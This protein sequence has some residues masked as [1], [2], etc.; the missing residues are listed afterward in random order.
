MA[1]KKWLLMY[2]GQ[3]ALKEHTYQE[4]FPIVIW[5]DDCGSITEPI[6]VVDDFHGK[7]AKM[8]HNDRGHWPHDKCA[9]AL[10]MCQACGKIVAR[11]NQE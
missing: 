10:Y 6:G 1:T 11:W 7:I 2:L 9:I 5:C 4:E 8:P 3:E